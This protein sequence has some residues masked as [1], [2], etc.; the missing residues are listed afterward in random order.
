ML[1]LA[2]SK[3]DTVHDSAFQHQ[4]LDANYTQ[5]MLNYYGNREDVLIFFHLV[6]E[7]LIIKCRTL[8]KLDLRFPLSLI[9]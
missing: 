3:D 8:D 6:S 2:F 1:C 7:S 9:I 4:H 5:I